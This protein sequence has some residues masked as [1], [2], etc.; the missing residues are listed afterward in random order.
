[1][2]KITSL[3]LA[4]TRAES[5]IA[6][7]ITNHGEK[8]ENCQSFRTLVERAGFDVVDIDLSRDTIPEDCRLLLKPFL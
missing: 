8:L 5:P 1:M 4:L 7:F 6:G 2:K 3:L